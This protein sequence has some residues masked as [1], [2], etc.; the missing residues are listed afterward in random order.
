[1]LY[2]AAII[3]FNAFLLS[4]NCSAAGSKTLNCVAYDFTIQTNKADGSIVVHEDGDAPIDFSVMYDILG[5]KFEVGLP[6][7]EMAKCRKWP[8]IYETASEI[9]MGC[10]DA[11]FI[12]GSLGLRVDLDS[13]R[14]KVFG[15]GILPDHEEFVVNG[16][17][18]CYLN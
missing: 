3:S 12:N 5:E 14:F 16:T 17:G 4:A 13:M 8:Y 1:M 2:K 15:I 7:F 9:S 11:D 6:I 10:M 18:E